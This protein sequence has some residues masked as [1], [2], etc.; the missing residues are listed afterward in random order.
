MEGD[1]FWRV[2]EGLAGS[3]AMLVWEVERTAVMEEGVVI[4]A[5]R[6]SGLGSL[7]CWI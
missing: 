1:W 5:A 3:E 4:L 6:R 7:W 2:I